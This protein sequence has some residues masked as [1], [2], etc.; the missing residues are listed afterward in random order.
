MNQFGFNTSI[1]IK[2]E[3]NTNFIKNIKRKLTAYVKS[4]DEKK[5]R[6][7][8]DIKTIIDKHQKQKG[9]CAL[10]SCEYS[11]SNYSKFSNDQ[12]SIDRIDSKLGHTK[13]NCQMVCFGCNRQKG[14]AI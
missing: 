3:G 1:I 10:C 2:P 6:N 7:D 12:F 4:D 11:C 8:L 5:L 14:N 9:L 13:S